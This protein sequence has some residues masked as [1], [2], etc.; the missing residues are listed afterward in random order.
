MLHDQDLYSGENVD[1]TNKSKAPKGP[2]FFGIPGK[3]FVSK[4]AKE[5]PSAAPIA[6]AAYKPPPAKSSP[7]KR[8]EPSGKKAAS[9]GK[10]AKKAESDGDDDPEYGALYDEESTS[11]AADSE[12]RSAFRLNE[13]HSP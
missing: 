1:W 8:K 4:Y 12:V 9:K 3:D 5:N 10:K 7:A 6:Q 13:G 2:G 11:S